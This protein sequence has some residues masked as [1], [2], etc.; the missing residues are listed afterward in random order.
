M[1]LSGQENWAWSSEGICNVV[2]QREQKAM[3][4]APMWPPGVSLGI[5]VLNFD[6][7]YTSAGAWEG[8]DDQP[9][10]QIPLGR[11]SGSTCQVI[12]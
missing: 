2:M 3:C 7:K 1:S 9:G 5:Y 4:W 10:A 8:D 11:A 12:L 6:V